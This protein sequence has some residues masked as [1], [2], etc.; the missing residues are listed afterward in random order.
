MRT[1]A[2]LEAAEFDRAAASY[3]NELNRGLALSGES[4]EYFARAR[5]AWLDGRLQ[6]LGARP[7][8]A[9]DFGCGTGASTGLLLGLSSIEHVIGV[10]PSVR[11]IEIAR[12]SWASDR[13]TFDVF[14]AQFKPVAVELAF[15][16][17]VLHHISRPDRG[18]AL[19]LV[20]QSVEVGGYFAVWE[21][22]ALSPAARAVMRRIPFDR[23]AEPI[24]ACQTRRLLEQTGFRI[25]ATDYLFIF[26]RIL[27]VLRPLENRLSRWPIGAQYLVLSRRD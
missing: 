4:R 15:C 1:H 11:S 23:D 18:A 25:V 17:G 2:T 16:N 27:R 6:R 24:T 7:R 26:P 21:N 9:L 8:T 13:V 3:D 12:R 19:R 10:D 5:V 22:N 20:Y 14:D